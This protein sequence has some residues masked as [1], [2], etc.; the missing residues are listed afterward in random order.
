MEH[1]STTKNIIQK[2]DCKIQSEILSIPNENFSFFFLSI[3]KEF[4]LFFLF[5][6]ISMQIDAS[7]IQTNNKILNTKKENQEFSLKKNL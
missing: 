4:F 5:M 6:Y 7:T 3:A 2:V 1:P